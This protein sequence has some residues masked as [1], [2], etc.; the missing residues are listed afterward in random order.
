MVVDD[1]VTVV[2]TCE[3][4]VSVLVIPL[5]RPLSGMILL[6]G[7]ATLGGCIGRVGGSDGIPNGFGSSVLTLAR[8]LERPD[9][10]LFIFIKN[11]F[12][13]LS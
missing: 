8:P 2:G 12:Y 7:L 11:A 10:I 6:T 13:I 1:E 4:V 9:I 3:V 5:P